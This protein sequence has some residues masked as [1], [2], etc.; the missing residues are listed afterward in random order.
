LSREVRS[1]IVREGS[2]QC[3]DRAM[4]SVGHHSISSLPRPQTHFWCSLFWT[5]KSYLAATDFTN[6]L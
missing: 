1:S 4:E 2:P 5:R 6:A 3:T